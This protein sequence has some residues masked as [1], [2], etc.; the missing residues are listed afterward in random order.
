[1]SLP[2]QEQFKKFLETSKEVLI[3]I[4][5]NPSADAV[6][7]A[8]ALYYFLEKMNILPAIAFSNH[9]SEKFSFL[10]RPENIL[11]EISGA[12]DFVLSFNTAENKI[13]RVRHEEKGDIFNIL[14]TPEKGSVNP[15]DFSFILAKF[16]YDL[17]IVIDSADLETLGKLYLENTDLF[18]EVPIINIDYKSDNDNFGQINLTDI[19]ASSSCE[20]L[21]R[22]FEET[23]PE[24]VDKKIATCLLA[25]LIGATDSFQKK[26]TTPKALLASANLMNKGADQQEIIRW[27]YKTQP[28]HI[29]KLWGRAMAK[30]NWDAQSKLVWSTLSVEDFVQSRSK[31]EDLP[32]IISKLEENYSE[33]QI[34]M[35]VYN[36]TPQSS[37]ALIKF[38]NPETAKKIVAEFPQNFQRGILE[39]NFKT[40]DIFEVGQLI[41]EKIKILMTK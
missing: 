26:N 12:R 1:M 18:F 28:L 9:L 8:W 10:P 41:A 2:P 36:D 35:A 27:M 6:G 34:F 11:S 14:V 7:S 39:I 32:L 16:K 31:S 20:I 13:I 29:L 4:P 25:G 23:F 30:I 38:S 37:V 19:T 17:V 5:E 24:L 15:K 3:L 21:A 33:G 40:S 22:T